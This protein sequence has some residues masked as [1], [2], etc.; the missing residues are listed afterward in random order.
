M[1]NSPMLCNSEQ[2]RLVYEILSLLAK[3]PVFLSSPIN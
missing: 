1:D 2:N 3:D